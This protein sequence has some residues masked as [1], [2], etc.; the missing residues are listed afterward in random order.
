[1]ILGCGFAKVGTVLDSMADLTKHVDIQIDISGMGR[2]HSPRIP[3]FG[4][5]AYPNFIDDLFWIGVPEL[6]SK[7]NKLIQVLV[8]LIQLHRQ[9][10]PFTEGTILIFMTTKA[11]L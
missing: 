10:H 1:M 9:V 6:S 5:N 11:G 2:F 7:V 4:G 3:Q 8:Y